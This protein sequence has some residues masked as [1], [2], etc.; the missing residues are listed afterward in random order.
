MYVQFK[1]NKVEFK[2]YRVVM[3]AKLQLLRKITFF[4]FFL[5]RIFLSYSLYILIFGNHLS[6]AIPRPICFIQSGLL[7]TVFKSRVEA[8]M[9]GQRTSS[10]G[11]IQF[12]TTLLSLTMVPPIVGPGTVGQVKK[13][14][15]LYFTSHRTSEL[16]SS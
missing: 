1:G 6:F 9:D 15:I 13:V 8:H 3:E 11:P 7:N 4:F 2:S 12:L 10:N 16:V 5:W 14:A